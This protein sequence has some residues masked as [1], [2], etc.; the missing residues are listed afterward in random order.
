MSNTNDNG[1]NHPA[2]QHILDALPESLHSVVLPELKKWDAGVTQRFQEIHDSYKD[3]K[4]F[5]KLVENGIAPDYVEQAVILADQLQRDPKKTVAQINESWQLGFVPQEALNN[6]NNSGDSDDDDFESSDDLFSDDILKSPKVKAMYESLNQIQE[7][8]NNRKQQ[9]EQ[10]NEVAEFEA[11]LDE[12][13]E[14]TTSNNLPFNRLFVTALMHQGV[15]GEE[16]VKQFHQVLAAGSTQDSG[17]ETQQSGEQ[18][19]SDSSGDQP[20]VVM[21]G[22]GTG[23]GIPDGSVNFGALSKNDLNSTIEQ[24]LAQAN[25]SGQG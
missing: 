12:L 7:E 11:Y 13:E 19:G 17:G 15:D 10:E 6:S 16:A 9:E 2:Y 8:L 3:L 24:L 14:Q 4:P 1:N 18:A 20:P 21:G 25:E 22:S 23:S 5:Q